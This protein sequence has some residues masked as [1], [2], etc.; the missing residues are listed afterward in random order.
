MDKFQLNINH[1]LSDQDFWSKLAQNPGCNLMNRKKKKHV[2]RLTKF[3]S[4]SE[5]PRF[6]VVIGPKLG[7]S[8]TTKQKG[9]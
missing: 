3:Q 9:G 1:H 8:V 4:T 5:R 2:D 7:Q 6:L